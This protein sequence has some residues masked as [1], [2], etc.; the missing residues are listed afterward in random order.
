MELSSKTVQYQEIISVWAGCEV[1]LYDDFEIFCQSDFDFLEI[2]MLL[3]KKFLV[4]LLD[5][6]KVRQ[7][8]G[9]VYEFISWA[10][11][12]PKIKKSFIFSISY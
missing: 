7:D 8:F 5:T 4:N 1:G 9:R 3:E 10:I 2:L 11:S 6:T 12:R